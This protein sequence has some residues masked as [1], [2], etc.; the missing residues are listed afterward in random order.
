LIDR[1]R[2]TLSIDF[3]EEIFFC[4]DRENDWVPLNHNE[5]KEIIWVDRTAILPDSRKAVAVRVS[6]TVHPVVESQSN[7]HKG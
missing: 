6:Q 2:S 7:A 3:E 5:R 4:Q 1:N